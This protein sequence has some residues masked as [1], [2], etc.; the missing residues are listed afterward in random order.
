M[1]KLPN[2]SATALNSARKITEF[3]Q[4]A[5][6]VA[7]EASDR[8]SSTTRDASS[9]STNTGGNNTTLERKPGMTAASLGQET[10]KRMRD[11]K[12]PERV[13]RT[14]TAPTTTTTTTTATTAPDIT[15]SPIMN[16]G[17]KPPPQHRALVAAAPV[18]E[19]SNS[20]TRK[21]DGEEKR[22]LRSKAGGTR[23]KSNLATYFPNFEDVVAGVEYTPGMKYGFA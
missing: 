6:T 23:L 15:K 21:K 20:S 7:V 3:F 22:S 2:R 14:A 9:S 11:G 19:S 13:T 8:G 17:L 1:L 4:P 12:A 10:R 18:G 16:G 5:Q